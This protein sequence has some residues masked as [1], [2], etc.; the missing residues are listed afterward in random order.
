MD[1]LITLIF[2]IAIIV[3][4]AK[5]SEQN[6]KNQTRSAQYTQAQGK[7]ASA[8]MRTQGGSATRRPMDQ[9]YANPTYAT[10]GY[11]QQRANVNQQRP[12]SQGELKA[13]LQQKYGQQSAPD[14]D[15]VTRAKKNASE[16]Q[17]DVLAHVMRDE[18]HAA[19]CSAPDVVMDSVADFQVTESNILGDVNEL[20]VKGYSGEMTFERDF[21]AEGVEMLNRFTL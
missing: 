3:K 13:R 4:I 7:Y 11:A 5:K 8:Q 12:V 6:K 15:I 9:R 2:F 10:P 18:A 20:I 14:E 19:E 16:E 17:E 1:A 21:I